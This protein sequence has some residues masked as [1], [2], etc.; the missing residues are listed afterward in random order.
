MI[1]QRQCYRRLLTLFTLLVLTSM[2][3][4][5]AVPAPP[6]GLRATV[7]PLALGVTPRV[8]L[9]WPTWDGAGEQPV[10]YYIYRAMGTQTDPNLFDSLTAEP[11]IPASDTG[12]VQL[13]FDLVDS[14]SVSYFVVAANQDGVSGPS[15]IA[16]VTV[17]PILAAIMFTTIPPGAVL[18]DSMTARATINQPFT[19]NA[20]A[21]ASNGGTV[22]YKLLHGPNGMTIDEATGLVQWTPTA[23]GEYYVLIGAG[24]QGDPLERMLAHQTFIIDVHECSMPAS[25]FGRVTDDNGI[26]VGGAEIAIYSP[27]GTPQSP[28]IR[29]ITNANG[30][31]NVAVDKGTYTIYTVAPS[32]VGE[33]YQDAYERG[34]AKPLTIDCGD[35]TIVNITLTREQ[36]A[37]HYS[38]SGTVTAKNGQQ[39]IEGVTVR[40]IGYNVNIPDSVKWESAIRVQTSTNARGEYMITLS[41][42]YRYLVYVSGFDSVSA[43]LYSAQYYNMTNDPTEA[44]ILEVNGNLT[45]IDFELDKIAPHD[46]GF[47]GFV[48]DSAGNPISA[49]VVAYRIT[50]QGNNATAEAVQSQII[51]QHDRGMFTFKGLPPGN[52]VIFATPSNRLYV[53]GYY[54]E[55]AEAVIAWQDATQIKLTNDDITTPHVI[56]LHRREGVPGKTRL[57][58][59]ITTNTGR[60]LKVERTTAGTAPVAG[61]LVAALDE[62]NAVSNYAFTDSEGRFEIT[63]LGSGQYTVVADKVGFGAYTSG[64]TLSGNDEAVAHDVHLES[65]AL[66]SV[67]DAGADATL[68]LSVHPNPASSQ[69]NLMFP[70]AAGKARVVVTNV[71]GE[72]VLTADLD[73]SGEGYRLSAEGLASGIYFVRLQAGASTGQAAVRIVR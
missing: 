17:H 73:R 57:R 44:T 53:P 26:G 32:M 59:V 67:P 11:A 8:R 18:G 45:G 3:A 16:S 6:Q 46:N 61:A 24:L 37:Q 2:M 71:Q 28:A 40:F 4:S 68:K 56:Q 66:S 48:R 19:Y 7:E 12:R 64:A 51:F 29:T 50:S 33:W 65:L 9:Q 55:N 10:I 23:L 72:I 62:N 1:T 35:S 52:Y 39:P 69:I 20:D 70:N 22:V 5:A 14:G 54:K 63:G 15:N 47:F 13:H 25:F 36:V 60:N 34:L 42:Q 43:D 58:G 49:T 27:L 41:S 31:F 30:Y 21:Q 38:V